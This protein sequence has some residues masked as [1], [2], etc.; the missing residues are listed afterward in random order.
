MREIILCA[1]YC[2][3]SAVIIIQLI[4]I[5]LCRHLYGQRLCRPIDRFALLVLS[6]RII[7]GN[8]IRADYKTGDYAAADFGIALVRGKPPLEQAIVMSSPY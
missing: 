6:D 1:L 2:G 8:R 3:G 7:Q 4:Q 5:R